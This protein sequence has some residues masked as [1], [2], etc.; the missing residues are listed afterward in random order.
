[1]NHQPQEL[2]DR[3]QVLLVTDDAW[4]EQRE[5]AIATHIATCLTCTAAEQAL[6]M[7]IAAYRQVDVPL[8]DDV[9]Q[10]LL[11]EVCS[12]VNTSP[13]RMSM[14]MSDVEDDA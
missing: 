8:A 11:V 2:C 13:A 3:L 4:S 6:T 10:R 12:A 5:Q 1:M 14:A 7:L 9:E